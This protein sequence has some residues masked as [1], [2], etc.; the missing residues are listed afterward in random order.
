MPEKQDFGITLAD[1]DTSELLEAVRQS[2]FSLS[3]K[4]LL[5]AELLD[6]ARNPPG[7]NSI[8]YSE[9]LVAVSTGNY[10][11]KTWLGRAGKAWVTA[12]RALAAPAV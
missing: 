7:L 1:G 5:W 8:M 3:L 9:P 2:S 4:R 6:P 10:V 11:A 12:L